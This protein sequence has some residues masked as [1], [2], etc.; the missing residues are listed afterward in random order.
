MAHDLIGLTGKAPIQRTEKGIAYE[1]FLRSVRET[2]A[3]M[4]EEDKEIAKRMNIDFM[5]ALGC[6][7]HGDS[8][9]AE[10][11]T[12]AVSPG[13]V[14]VDT[15]LAQMSVMYQNDEFIGPRLMPVVPVTYRS[16]KYA[17][18][19]KRD[20]FNFPEDEITS[21]SEPN[22]VI[23]GRSFD[24]YS[25]KDYAFSNF[26]DLETVRNQD[27]VF[28]EMVDL[29]DA[30]NAGLA[31][32]REKR[33]LAIVTASGN[34]AGNT[35]APG[36]DWISGNNGGSVIADITNARDAVWR[37]QGGNRLIGFTT[38]AVWNGGILNNAAL[39][40]RMKYVQTGLITPQ[41]VATWFGLDEIL[42]IKG[43]EETANLGQT[44]SYARMSAT[45]DVFGIVS[46]NQNPTKRSVHFGST[47]R[48]S[49]TPVTTQWFDAAV[50]VRGGIKAKVA[51]SEDHKIV[52][53]DAGFLIT[54]VQT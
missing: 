17:V 23:E 48:V 6:P 14:H 3:G 44:A 20:R 21:R 47:F 11:E 22:E 10:L 51:V 37:G 24:N 13:A 25:V 5:R 18:Y 52:A 39:A 26:L 38:L 4:S 32:K 46:V 53:G 16:D 19:N 30:I 49:D 33:I 29:V 7:V 9:A 36:T 15:V 35:A 1:T 45:A 12:R 28:D 42:I 50:G 2:L 31:F 8:A 43:R 41:M 27:P 40:E 34:Y 54:S